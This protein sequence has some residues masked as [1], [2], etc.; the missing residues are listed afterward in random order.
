MSIRVRY[1]PSP[2]G[3]QHIG[4]LRTALFNYFFARSMHGTFILRIEDTDRTRFDPAALQDIYDTFSWLGIAWDEGPDKN[5]PHAPYLQ[6]ERSELYKKYAQQLLQ[7]DQA[8]PCYCSPERLE[9]LRATQTEQKTAFGY[10][11]HCR[12]LTPQQRADYEKQGISPVIR[13]KIPLEGSTVLHDELLGDIER[14]N[15]DINPDPV[16]LKSD[17]FP[18]YHLANI[19]DDHLMEISHVL[20]AQ[21]WLSSG[22]L[23]VLLYQAFGWAP[24]KYCHLPMVMGQDGQKLSKR[25]GSTAVREF[26]EQGYLKEALINYISL[27]GWAYDDKTEFFSVEELSRLFSLDKLNKSP[28]VFDYKKLEWFNGMYIRKLSAEELAGRLLPFLQ[29]D[30]LVGDP[31][32]EEELSRIRTIIP[33]VQ[34]RLNL[35]SDVSALVRFLFTDIRVKEAAELIPKKADA[36]KTV[37]ILKKTVELINGFDTRSDD[38]NEALFR[39]AADELGVKL[40]QLLMPLRVAITATTV[41]PPLFESLRILGKQKTLDRIEQALTLLQQ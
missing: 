25:H 8:Y 4:G 14:A 41:S 31:A 17:G 29:K 37:E 21:E 2:T 11:R 27:L 15:R 13:F 3:K 18:T 30:G 24:P 38:E 5:G 1:A 16:L 20:R 6:S 33:L 7:N 40:G 10:D 34:E 23:H 32:S 36:E 26:R 19:V 12:N 35:L 9:K 39:A 22:P 28:A